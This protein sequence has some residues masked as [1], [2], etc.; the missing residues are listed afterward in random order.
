MKDCFDTFITNSKK[1][2][3]LCSFLFIYLSIYSFIYL[4]IFEA[5]KALFNQGEM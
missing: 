3:G 2:L 1:A 4:F 5:F